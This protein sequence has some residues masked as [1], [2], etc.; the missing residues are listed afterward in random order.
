M[1]A[2]SGEAAKVVGYD[3]KRVMIYCA[4]GVGCISYYSCSWKRIIANK[5]YLMH[6]L[7]LLPHIDGYETY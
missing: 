7:K 2:L 3:I 4:V 6:K 1:F 5:V